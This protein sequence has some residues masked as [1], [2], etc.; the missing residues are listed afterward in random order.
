MYP[1][2]SRNEARPRLVPRAG[3]EFRAARRSRRNGAAIGG[4][5]AGRRGAWL[6]LDAQAIGVGGLG[7]Y[8]VRNAERASEPVANIGGGARPALRV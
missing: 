6:T 1:F 7:S 5:A 3:W 2:S 4:V 8:A